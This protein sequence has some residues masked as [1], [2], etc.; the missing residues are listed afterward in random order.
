MFQNRRS[1]AA[2]LF[3][4]LALVAAALSTAEKAAARS[5][6]TLYC[7]SED[8]FFI[9]CPFQGP[10]CPCNTCPDYC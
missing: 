10:E 5:C 9:C 6:T 2:A 4:A 3:T 1:F 7:P 8:K